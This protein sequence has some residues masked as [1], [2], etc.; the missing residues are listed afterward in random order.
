MLEAVIFDMDGVLLNSEPLH[1]A[2]DREIFRK[3]G[4]H[5]T[6]KEQELFLGMGA[7]GTYAWLKDRFGLDEP[8]E[9][10]LRMDLEIRMQY[11]IAGP[12]LVPNEG[13][14]QLLEEL[15]EN[16]VPLALGSST[17]AP[18]VD[19]VLGILGLRKYFL[20]IVTGDQVL[21][22]KPDPSIFLLC[23]DGLG[24][25]PENCLV[26]ED[27]KNGIQAARTAG[28]KV[29]GYCLN[30]MDQLAFTGADI[31]VQHF[32]EL[33]FDIVRRIMI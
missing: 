18:I 15:S 12:L 1:M 8:L 17:V 13:V 9:E 25:S 20:R 14:I 23:A 2:A 11:F 4:F 22:T 7:E 24:V 30:G 3:L 21:K 5:V 6:P 26:I 32:S 29:A 33:S 10:L 16:Q 28:M 27:S 31:I 19:R